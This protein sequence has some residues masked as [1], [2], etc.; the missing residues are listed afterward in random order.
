MDDPQQFGG[1]GSGTSGNNSFGTNGFGTGNNGTGNSLGS[2]FG[3]GNGPTIGSSFGTSSG[4]NTGSSFGTGTGPTIS[5]SFDASSRSHASSFTSGTP[6]GDFGTAGGPTIGSSFGPTGSYSNSLDDARAQAAAQ[7]AVIN[8]A[9]N[10]DL[11]PQMNPLINPQ[12]DPLINPQ[13]NPLVNPAVDPLVNPAGDPPFMPGGTTGSYG[14]TNPYSATSGSDP[15]QGYQPTSPYSQANPGIGAATPSVTSTGTAPYTSAAAWTDPQAAAQNPASYGTQTY[16]PMYSAYSQQQPAQGAVPSS[17]YVQFRAPDTSPATDPQHGGNS[18]H[19]NPQP[20]TQK[21]LIKRLL[22]IIVAMVAVVAVVIGVNAIVAKAD[23]PQKE[24]EAYMNTLKDGRFADARAM[25][26]GDNA[27]LTDDEAVLLTNDAITDASQRITSYR[28]TPAG[29]GDTRTRKS[30]DAEFTLGGSSYTGTISFIKSDGKWQLKDSL[31]YS[32]KVTGIDEVGS[33]NINGK[34]VS[35]SNA[36]KSS[37]SSDSS[38]S[39]LLGGLY[40]SGSQSGS[41]DDDLSW[42]WDTD[43]GTIEIA[44]YP[45]VYAGSTPSG[46]DKYISVTS[47][48]PATVT[49]KVAPT[50]TFTVNFSDQ[51]FTELGQQVRAKFDACA[52]Q[53]NAGNTEATECANLP[54][55]N[56]S[57]LTIASTD[58]PTISK[59]DIIEGSDYFLKR[60]Q[61][62]YGS[63]MPQ[64]PDGATWGEFSAEQ[65]YSYEYDSAQGT[66]TAYFTALYIIDNG[67]LTVTNME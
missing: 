18:D 10:P 31:L 26:T 44:A 57:G 1:F 52:A 42:W 3:T 27:S 6:T 65:P 28:L 19:G 39:G 30:Y 5:S 40:G 50:L 48:G 33:V 8:P 7:R 58:D 35:D 22:I 12:A 29:T 43:T 17:P 61:Q 24:A 64:I 41:D 4:S 38:S 62:Y 60:L 23:T 32:L 15:A 37:S 53:I 46:N 25:E 13:M 63:D 9:W 56:P 67:T 47:D 21:K 49:S 54:L 51:L 2:D 66:S 45:G 34:Q 16:S 55:P 11:N 59:D 36:L 14:S 20:G